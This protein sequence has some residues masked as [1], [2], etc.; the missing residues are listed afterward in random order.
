[1][2]I[3]ERINT[4]RIDKAFSLTHFAEKVGISKQTLYKYEKGIVTNIPLDKIEAIAK[5]LDT[6]PAYIM[7]WNEHTPLRELLEDDPA[8]KETLEKFKYDPV[9]RRNLQLLID[10]IKEVSP[11]YEEL[12]ED[13]ARIINH[14]QQFLQLSTSGK[15]KVIDY[16][17]LV[18]N[19]EKDK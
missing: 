1:M 7:G 3:G 17:E 5:A 16:T 18:Y 13:N 12:A 4:K 6:T 11:K 15:E 19:S 14:F 2:T 9:Y 8:W 10:A